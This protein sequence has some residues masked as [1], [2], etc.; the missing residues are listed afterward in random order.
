[1]SSEELTSTL[2]VFPRWRRRLGELTA[3]TAESE[4]STRL[5]V[6]LRLLF[7]KD[8]SRIVG[9][10]RWEEGR[11]GEGKL[12][13]LDKTDQ[14]D[15]HTSRMTPSRLTVT[16]RWPGQKRSGSQICVCELEESGRCGR[17]REY[18]YELSTDI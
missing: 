3:E 2:V 17:R 9:A 5:Q 18:E 1:M 10:S 12:T 6:S 14:A 8:Q 4:R 13:A 15:H 11:E 16:T 7:S